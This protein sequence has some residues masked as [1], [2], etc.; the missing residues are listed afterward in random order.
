MFRDSEYD[1]MEIN[2]QTKEEEDVTK[3]L[4]DLE[5]ENK[6]IKEDLGKVYGKISS[7]ESR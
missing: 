1:L 4:L 5:A 2:D 7:E 6:I 3:K